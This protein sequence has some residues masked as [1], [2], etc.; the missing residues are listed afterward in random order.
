MVWLHPQILCWELNPNA[1]VWR[2]FTGGEQAFRD[3]VLRIRFMMLLWELD[4]FKRNHWHTPLSLPS[5][6]LLPPFPWVTKHSKKVLARCK[7]PL[8]PLFKMSQLL[9]LRAGTYYGNPVSALLL[10]Q[11]EAGRDRDRRTLKCQCNQTSL[12]FIWKPLP[13]F[14]IWYF[15]SLAS[16]LQYLT[17]WTLC[18]LFIEDSLLRAS[19][20]G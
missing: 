4:S 10:G 8:I 17:A 19:R 13:A 12:I 5:S 6:L 2:S 1:S 9:D 3:S 20:G 15:V 16:C 18:F 14:Q 7:K 11:C